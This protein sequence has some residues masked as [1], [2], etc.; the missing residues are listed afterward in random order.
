[1][2]RPTLNEIDLER[3]IEQIGRRPGLI[4]TMAPDQWDCLLSCAYDRG[5]LLLEAKGAGTVEDPLQVFRAYR[6]GAVQ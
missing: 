6:K 2:K 3:A 5:A 1:M 4:L